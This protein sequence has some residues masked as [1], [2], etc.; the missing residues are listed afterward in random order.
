MN[1]IVVEQ[2]KYF[3]DSINQMSFPDVIMLVSFLGKEWELRFIRDATDL[4]EV[5]IYIDNFFFKL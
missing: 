2:E 4:E 1:Y 3:R 5:K